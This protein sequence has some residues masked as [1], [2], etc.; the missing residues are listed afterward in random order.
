M[1]IR[2]G[3]WEFPNRGEGPQDA[4]LRYDKVVG[5][6]SGTHRHYL[7]IQQNWD[8][9]WSKWG[10]QHNRVGVYSIDARDLE[11]VAMP[12]ADI[13]NGRYDN[14]IRERAQNLLAL[15][16]STGTTARAYIGFH[17]EPENEEVGNGAEFGVCGTASEYKAAGERFLGIV[18]NVMGDRCRIGATL[19]AGSY[20]G[21]HG[22]HKAWQPNNSWWYGVDGYAHGNPKET[23]GSIF[24][25]AHSA[26]VADGRRLVIQETGA[27][28]ITG[29]NFKPQFFHDART[30]PK[31]WSECKLIQY[32]NVQ[33]KSAYYV[34]T[35]RTSLAAFQEWAGDLFYRG[36]WT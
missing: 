5:F 12:W 29:T 35:T 10:F 23:F 3:R 15:M 27:P 16:V 33:A 14:V 31:S 21:G 19:M 26:A 7:P 9:S 4:A 36:D 1:T 18:D 24:T 6:P 28:E 30:I 11:K 2:L 25:P 22:G 32:S 17:H 13:A 8:G 34:D 20:S